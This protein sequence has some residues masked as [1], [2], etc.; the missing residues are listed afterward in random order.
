MDALA[1]PLYDARAGTGRL[2][3]ASMMPMIQQDSG[4]P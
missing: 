1:A 2:P 3:Q 4:I